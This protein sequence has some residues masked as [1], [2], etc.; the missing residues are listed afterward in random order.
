MFAQGQ[1]LGDDATP[2]L[3]LRHRHHDR[4]APSILDT[5]RDDVYL[6]NM[7]VSGIVSCLNNR[8]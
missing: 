7:E 6:M 8:Q 1:E 2:T 3:P 4:Q 5:S